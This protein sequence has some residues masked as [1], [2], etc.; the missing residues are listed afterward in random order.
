MQQLL[1]PVMLG[2][3]Y[4]FMIRPQQRR[5]REQRSLISRTSNGDRVVLTSGIYGLVLDTNG[6]VLKIGTSPDT[7]VYVS[8]AAIGRRVD[9]TDE[10]SPPNFMLAS[11]EDIAAIPAAEAESSAT[12]GATAAELP[13]GPAAA[14]DPKSGPAK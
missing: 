14:S 12:P 10:L 8:R 11:E 3:L 7:Y 5:A 4:F 9:P 13:S 2:L 1:L 6:D